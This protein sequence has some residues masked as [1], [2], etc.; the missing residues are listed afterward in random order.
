[1]KR[2]LM[3]L[4]LTVG[5]LTA[6]LLPPTT[7]AQDS[8]QRIEITA[9]RFTFTPGEITL[10]K[11]RPVVLVITSMDVNH[12]FRIREFGVNAT[13]NAGRTIEVAFTPNKTGDFVAH[14]SVYCGPG[15]GSMQLK[16]HVVA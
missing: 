7:F 9:K 1:M 14:C 5:L 12:G 16:L 2:L 6:A 8:P 11:G 4:S 10:K 13:V 15:H 3:L